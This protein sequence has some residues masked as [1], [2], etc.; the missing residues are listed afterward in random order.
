[1]SHEKQANSRMELM[2]LDSELKKLDTIGYMSMPDPPAPYRFFRPV[3]DFKIMH[4]DCLL[5]GYQEE[6][7]ELQIIHTDGR[8]LQ[9]LL[10]LGKGYMSWIPK[11]YNKFPPGT[12]SINMSAWQ[13]RKG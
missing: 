4:N 11:E 10:I 7:Y 8:V 2:K 12:P 5:Y 13:L 1:M 6:A 3:I 9:T